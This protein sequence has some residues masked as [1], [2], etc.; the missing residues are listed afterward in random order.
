[1]RFFKNNFFVVFT[2]IRTIAMSAIY[3]VFNLFQFVS[4]KTYP[5]LLEAIDLHG[6]L[7]VYSFCCLIGFIFVLFV[8]KETSGQSLDD[9]GHIDD[10]SDIIKRKI[11]ANEILYKV[12]YVQHNQIKI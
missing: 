1:M 12:Y 9:I 3:A 5:I 7:M 2:Q 8:L 6:C 4:L 11:A 10:V